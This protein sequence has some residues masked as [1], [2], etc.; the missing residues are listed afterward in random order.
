MSQNVCLS[1][2]QG[3]S[4]DPAPNSPACSPRRELRQVFRALFPAC[5]VS[6]RI[7]R[8]SYASLR[9][10]NNGDSSLEVGAR[11]TLDKLGPWIPRYG[12]D[13]LPP[14]GQ[15]TGATPSGKTREGLHLFAGVDTRSQKKNTTSESKRSLLCEH[16]AYTG[17]IIYETAQ[18]TAR[19]PCIPLRSD[20]CN[21][22][23]MV[24]GP[25]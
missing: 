2:T 4:S 21:S 13:T 9:S 1:H 6:L 18:R 17:T 19:L 25:S 12:P 5:D 24:K 3:T 14:L 15:Q 7:M 22:S 11:S 20:S 8:P 10:R 23:S 16:V